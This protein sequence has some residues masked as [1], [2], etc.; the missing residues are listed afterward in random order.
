MFIRAL[1]ICSPPYFDSEIEII[2]NIGKKLCYS[3]SFIDECF[4][5]ARKSVYLP[6]NNAPINMESNILVLS[7]FSNFIHIKKIFQCLNIQI[8]FKNDITL[9]RIVIK[10]SPNS[11]QNIAYNIPCKDY[12]LSYIGQ[13]SKTLTKR[14]QR[15][16]YEVR[17]AF[18]T[19][20][21]FS[22]IHQRDHRVDWQGASIL[23]RCNEIVS[24][25]LAESALIQLLQK[26]NKLLSSSPG[27]Y[28][29]DLFI[30]H[31]FRSDF[32]NILSKF[33]N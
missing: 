30:L 32:P 19:N 31:L 21:L 18:T 25:N 15:H 10:N 9:K 1:R 20:S 7:Y 2:Y 5:R 11:D 29:H 3:V 6:S 24:R 13:T 23:T 17:Q 16:K 28:I 26:D 12:N 4:R 27:L 22:L 33:N 14:V 8:V